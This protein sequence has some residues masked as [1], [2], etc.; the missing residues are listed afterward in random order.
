MPDQDA[1]SRVAWALSSHDAS[2]EL[3]A[4]CPARPI[5]WESYTPLDVILALLMPVKHRGYGAYI[6]CDGV[7]L[8]AHKVGVDSKNRTLVSCYV[9]SEVGKVCLDTYLPL[10]LLLSACTGV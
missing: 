10:H 3:L 2:D 4:H 6:S 1:T 7:E 9:A 8:E 5:H